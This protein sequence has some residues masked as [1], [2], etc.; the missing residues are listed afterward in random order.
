MREAYFIAINYFVDLC[1]LLDIIV[2]FRTTFTDEKTGKEESNPKKIAVRYLKSRFWIDLL[3]TLP[4]DEIMSWFVDP[5]TAKNFQLLG[6]LKLMR[7]LRLSR[8]ITYLN[9]KGDV[10][11]SLKLSK[12]IY[13]LVMY[14]HC[15][16]CTWYF[17]VKQQ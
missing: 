1:F 14:L 3:A 4:M 12:L 5:A 17:I 2:V 10:K 15:Q 6:V 9:V 7:V 11:V 13:Y 16:G 8:I